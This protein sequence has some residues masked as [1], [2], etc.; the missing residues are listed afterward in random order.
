[1]RYIKRDDCEGI[2]ILPGT[3]LRLACCDCGL[4]HDMAWVIEDNGNLGVAF[5]RHKRATAQLR[6]NG[7]GL[8]Q[9]GDNKPYKMSRNRV[10]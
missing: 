2:E 1:M 5:K 4:V 8:L 7:Y 9:Q 6:R 10:K 3:L